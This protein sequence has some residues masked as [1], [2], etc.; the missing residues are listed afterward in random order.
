MHMASGFRY[1]LRIVFLCASLICVAGFGF[2]DDSASADDTSSEFDRL[3]TGADE[4]IAKDD[5]EK[6]LPLLERLYALDPENLLVIEWLGKIHTI[7]PDAPPEYVQALKF[8]NEASTKGSEDNI[9][10]YFLGCIHAS[11]G[12]S[13]EAIRQLE[14]AFYHGYTDLDTMLDN[15]DFDPIRKTEWWGSVERN[16][17][18]I[19]KALTLYWDTVGSEEELSAKDRRKRLSE[20]E[21][22]LRNLVPACSLVRV[23]VLDNLGDIC[24]EDGGLQGSLTYREQALALMN[25]TF[26]ESFPDAPNLQNKV[27]IVQFRMGEWDGSIDSFGK[28]VA[29]SEALGVARSLDVAQFLDNGGDAYSKKGD[30]DSAIRLYLQEVGLRKELSGESDHKVPILLNDIGIQYM[31]KTDYTK[32]FDY[33]E[34]SLS[35]QIAITGEKNLN[36]ATICNNIGK[37]YLE[38]KNF[39]K[40][41]EYDEKALAIQRELFGEDSVE[42]AEIYHSLGD[43]YRQTGDLPK[44]L[45]YQQDAC[46]I[47]LA[48]YGERNDSTLLAMNNLGAIYWAMG[49]YTKA[50]E[51]LDKAL[52]MIIELRGESNN[53]VATMYNNLG[54]MWLARGDYARSRYNND[55][56]LAIQLKVFGENHPTNVNI[57]NSL[58]NCYGKQGD[59]ENALANY[60]KALRIQNDVFGSENVVSA[61]ILNNIGFAYSEMG[62]YDKAKSFF[63]RALA[64][65]LSSLGPWHAD[66]ATTYN[67]LAL[68]YSSMRDYAKAEELLKKTLEIRIKAL[69]ETH[70]DVAMSYHNIGY[71]CNRTG[72]IDKAI[73]YAQKALDVYRKALGEEH[74]DTA[75]AYNNLGDDYR[76]KGQNE[77]ALTCF[78]K[79]LEIYRKRMGDS[80]PGCA[81][82]LNNIG[83]IYLNQGDFE[84]SYKYCRD[85]LAILDKSS[86]YML[87][88]EKV[89]DYVKVE[90]L[91]EGQDDSH[92]ALSTDLSRASIDTGIRAVERARIDLSSARTGIMAKSIPLYFA[93]IDLELRKGDKGK[94][95]AYS[96]AMRSRGFLDQMGT[97][98]ALRLDSVTKEER[99]RVRS[100]VDEISTSRSE[101]EALNG[102]PDDKRNPDDVSRVGSRLAAS[103]TA[104]VELDE[105]I[106]RR[107]PKYA[108]LR[109]PKPI[110]LATAQKWCGKDRVILEYVMWDPSLEQSLMEQYTATAGESTYKYPDIKLGSYCI[111]VS[112]DSIDYVR[113]DGDYDYVGAINKL[114]GFILR[115]WSFEKMEPLRNELYA[116]LIEPVVG[117]LPTGAQEIVV[118]PDG[119]IAYLP[120]DILRRD[121]SCPVF[122]ESYSVALSPSIS[123]SALSSLAKGKSQGY[124]LALGGGWYNPEKKVAERGCE[125]RGYTRSGDSGQSLYYSED[126]LRSLNP[127]QL[128]NARR[129]VLENGA[130]R[131]FS[132]RGFRWT[133]IPGTAREVRNLQDCVF[134]V[135]QITLLEGQSAS[136][137]N[138]KRLSNKG[139]LRDYS[140]IHLACHGYFDS[141][142]PDMSSVVLSEVSGLLKDDPE[143]GY[144][145]IAE[146]VLLD[147]DAD[148]VNLSACETG[149]AQVRRGDGMIGLAR[150]FLVAGARNVGVSLWSV[151]DEATTEFMTRLYKKAVGSGIGF[152]KAYAAVKAEFREDPKWSHPYY[153]AAFTMYE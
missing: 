23:L 146:T 113:L 34:R 104:L 100:L 132:E 71:V 39:T 66:V 41:L 28:A 83:I 97:E 60:L 77:L 19:G 46:R 73:W 92:A 101:L 80:Y 88:I 90:N 130:G 122:G 67:N 87:T 75:T 85:A 150:S 59:Y 53:L 36:V 79:S 27:G 141:M 82:L 47:F 25:R 42:V 62:D 142:F 129:V 69:G 107:V 147:L 117:K 45:S 140:V 18:E 31:K 110:D 64:I 93:G 9:V 86:N 63:E 15:T 35:A 134:P 76:A 121:A 105:A 138:L 24:L 5:F 81:L 72:D 10:Y 94:A 118:V 149:L 20:V 145:T 152:Q 114:R 3:A 57:Y 38:E 58:A 139:E 55:K 11:M 84:R 12:R 14:T 16:K 96:E 33:F 109:N 136:E 99:E 43:L 153:W 65:Y 22:S 116:K 89:W 8:L 30:A 125:S 7:L 49:D 50:I 2:A 98:A 126:E 78:E 131:Y 127:A 148:M 102:L 61:K 51:Y 13:D 1:R 128:A 74:I 21:A 123:V 95:F 4:L 115:R 54:E 68:V 106:G 37:W 91:R 17:V 26:G 40:A 6:A 124:A 52:T 48:H 56:A 111:I 151:D 112:S 108:Q 70:A 143:D 137:A 44:A 133:D 144:L 119:P 120:L 32:A 29:L 103:E 135:G